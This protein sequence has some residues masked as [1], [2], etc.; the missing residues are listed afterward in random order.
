M[1]LASSKRLRKE[2]Q[3]LKKSPDSDIFLIPDPNNIRSIQGF[4]R[5]P[6]ST[7]F[8]NGIYELQIDISQ[9][10]PMVPPS[11]KFVTKIFH[12]NVHFDTGEICLDILKSEWS[13][14]WGLQPACRAV[15]ALMSD[16]AA[17]SPLNCDAGN[18]IRA[19]DMRAYHAV[20][21]MYQIEYALKSVP[22]VP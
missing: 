15:I 5:G 14:A 6:P 9:N 13:P 12:P 2:I 17:D 8:E 22:C 10:Y 11:M 20:A 18:M 16:P 19:G 7:P 21:S 3:N 4:I 1:A